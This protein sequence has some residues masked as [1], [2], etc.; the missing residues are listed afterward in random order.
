MGAQ[1]QEKDTEVLTE[2]ANGDD[3]VPSN[4]SSTSKGKEREVYRPSSRDKLH[5]PTEKKSSTKNKGWA[6]GMSVGNTGALAMNTMGN[7]MQADPSSGPMFSDKLDLPD[8]SNGILNIPDGRELVFEGGVP[9]L[10]K[11]FASG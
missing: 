9:Y 3:V 7:D 2:K 8:V 6:I 4:S 5:L 11:K 10:R 1:I